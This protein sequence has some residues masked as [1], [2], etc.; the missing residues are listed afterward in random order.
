MFFGQQ[1][2]HMLKCMNKLDN[3]ALLNN[4]SERLR[5]SQQQLKELAD[6]SYKFMSKLHYIKI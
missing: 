6:K 4:W 3:P 5:H 1:L 2:V